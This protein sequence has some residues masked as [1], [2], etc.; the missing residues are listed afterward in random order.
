[1]SREIR[2]QRRATKAKQ[3]SCGRRHLQCGNIYNPAKFSKLL[4]TMNNYIQKN[5]KLRTTSWKRFS[6]WSA[7]R[8]TIWSSPQEW[9][10]LT[11][12]GTSTRKRL[13]WQSLPRKRITRA[14]SKE[15]INPMKMNQTR[16]HSSMT[17]DPP[18]SRTRSKA[19][20]VTTKWRQVTA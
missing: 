18:S 4:K 15:R 16:G 13:T 12:K 3:P 2:H 8:L 1:M 17:N 6:N 20:K 19:W 7:Q 9:N 14:W 5:Y 10:T 11:T